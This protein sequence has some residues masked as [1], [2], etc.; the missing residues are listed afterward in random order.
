MSH[1]HIRSAQPDDVGLIIGFIRELAEYEKLSDQV[2]ADPAQMREHLFGTRP[3]AEVLI[4][5]VNDAAAGFALFFHNY[6]TFLGKPG[7]YLEDLYVRS[8]ARGTGLGTALLGKLASLA[9]ERGCGRLEWSVLDWNE[10]A[11]DFYKRL[12]AQPLDDWTQYRLTGPALHELSQRS[13]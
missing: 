4:G 11:V 10:P 3:F 1:L 8:S 2:V 12:G 13:V 6:S 5:E 7:I 9:I